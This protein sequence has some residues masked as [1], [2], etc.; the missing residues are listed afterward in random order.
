MT[1]PQITSI[2]VFFASLSLPEL[3]LLLVLTAMVIIFEKCQSYFD[4]EH[5][6]LLLLFWLSSG[7]CG[8]QM[9]L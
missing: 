5:L 6:L 3:I 7:I 9:G 2:W 4:S 1:L 8:R